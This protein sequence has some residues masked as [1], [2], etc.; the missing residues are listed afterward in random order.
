M[1]KIIATVLVMI[2]TMG[3]NSNVFAAEQIQTNSYKE[4]L[5]SINKEYNLSLGYVP[6]DSSV[7]IEKYETTA[8]KVAIQERELLDYI[9]SRE[10]GRLAAP[11]APNAV[12]LASSTVKTKT[13]SVWNYEDYFNITATFTISD[14]S[15]ISACRNA[16][17]KSTST[18]AITNTYLTNISG[19]TYKVIDSGLTST[20]KY[21][22]TLH[23]DSLIGFKNTSL[24]TEFY[25][26]D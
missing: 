4:V 13:K 10:T 23:F 19:P 11:V 5:D 22:A 2:M 18:A 21:T 15:R 16:K 9:A 24:Y 6:V 25:Y 20:V 14:G 17:L 7:S 8:R 26:S 3:L 12:T 1:K